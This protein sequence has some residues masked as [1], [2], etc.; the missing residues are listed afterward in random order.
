M[1]G[2]L[3]VAGAAMLWGLW[4]VWLHASSVDGPAAAFTTMAIMSLPAVVVLRRAPFAD[5]GAVWA[6]VAVGVC[7]A[8]TAGL[9]FTSVNRGPVVVAVLTHY[10]TPLVVALSAPWLLG[11]RRSTRALV[12]APLVLGALAAMLGRPEGEGVVGTG[13]LGGASAFTYAGIVVGS[14]RAGK[15]FTPIQVT[16]LHAPISALLALAVFRG[17]AL[18]TSLG[19][20]TGRAIAG[21][22]LSGLLGTILFNSGLRRITSST[23]STLTYLEPVVSA[24]VGV[25]LFHEPFSALTV[26]GVGVVVGTGVWVARERA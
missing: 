2:V 1:S 5:R 12:A 15:S 3:M 16:A 18:P 22:L 8:L 25:A 4:P 17:D 14:K 6:L 24:L 10:L 11:E 13:L 23:A 9:Y 19:L 7:D 20:D 21:G 26:V